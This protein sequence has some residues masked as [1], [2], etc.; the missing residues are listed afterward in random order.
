MSGFESSH[1]DRAGRGF[2][3]HIQ[4]EQNMWDYVY[5]A[6]YL[7]LKDPTACTGLE[8]RVSDLMQRQ[9]TSYVPMGMARVGRVQGEVEA[10]STRGEEAGGK[11]A[12]S[13]G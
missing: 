10:D 5:L 1:F 12:G 13:T 9:L 4:H 11:D 6:G 3:Y 2:A 8:S 7:R